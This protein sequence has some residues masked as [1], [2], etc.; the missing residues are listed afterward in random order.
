M[1]IPN[2]QSVFLAFICT[3]PSYENNV[4]IRWAVKYGMSVGPYSASDAHSLFHSLY[5]ALFL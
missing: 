4:L 2:L 3:F 5:I 1:W